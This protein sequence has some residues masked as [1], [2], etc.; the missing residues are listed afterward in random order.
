VHSA[1]PGM[2]GC[3]SLSGSDRPMAH[4]HNADCRHHIQQTEAAI[5]VAVLNRM[6]E[7]GPKVRP[8]PTGRRIAAWESSRPEQAKCTNCSSGTLVAWR[9]WWHKRLSR[10]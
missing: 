5:G 2:V 4:K 7:A 6:L 9:L 10:M 1:G 8:S 3:S